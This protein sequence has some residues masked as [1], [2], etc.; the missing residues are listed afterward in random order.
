M[1]GGGRDIHLLTLLVRHL[2]RREFATVPQMAKHLRVPER[3]VSL[4]VGTNPA[5]FRRPEET[6]EA[7]RGTDVFSRLFGLLWARPSEPPSGPYRLQLSRSRRPA[8]GRPRTEK[9]PE[10]VTRGGYKASEVGALIES[11]ERTNEAN[12][13]AARLRVPAWILAAAAVLAALVASGGGEGLRGALVGTPG[14]PAVAS[15]ACPACTPVPV[16]LSCNACPAPAATGTGEQARPSGHGP[17]RLGTKSATIFNSEWLRLAAILLPLGLGAAL[18]ARGQLSGEG[19][20]KAPILTL[21]TALTII[22]GLATWAKPAL[23]PAKTASLHDAVGAF[24]LA[25]VLTAAAMLVLGYFLRG[26]RGWRKWLR[27]APLP[28]ASIGL[29]ALTLA[30]ESSRHAFIRDYLQPYLA[31][32][33]PERF[34]HGTLAALGLLGLG[35]AAGIARWLGKWPRTGE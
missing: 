6:A 30:T 13:A 19:E 29:L 33:G 5:I 28:V 18:L 35:L 31:A 3:D 23:V 17:T 24:L 1:M 11:L 4:T 21:G 22:G 12:R 25:C 20:E 7:D 15:G 27:N 14:R 8:A 9:S 26:F 16:Q 32:P 34:Y 10:P 2:A